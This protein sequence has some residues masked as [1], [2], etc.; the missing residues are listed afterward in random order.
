MEGRS[1]LEA[2]GHSAGIMT[3]FCRERAINLLD[4]RRRV[5]AMDR[6]LPFAARALAALRTAAAE[7]L[8]PTRC[9]VCDAPGALLCPRCAA[10]LPFVDANRACPRCGAPHGR[11]QCTECCTTLLSAAGREAFPLAGAASAVA[12]DDAARR[13]VIAL[14][15]HSEVRLAEPVGLLMAACVPPSWLGPAPTVAFVPATSRAVARR[16][17]DHGELLARAVAGRLGLAWAPLLGRPRSADQRGLGRRARLGNMARRFP[18]APGAAAP[19]RVL[20]VDDVCTTGATLYSA[21]D[22]LAEAGASEVYGLTF[23]RAGS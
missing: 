16:G 17:F 4:G 7:T 18:L 8:W 19:E 23:A 10:A 9:A 14:K 21:A 12:L 3:A 22:A 5:D 15:D 11:Y 6:D 20:L 13:L 2:Q 1:L